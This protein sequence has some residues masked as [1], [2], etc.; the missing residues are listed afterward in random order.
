MSYKID[1]ETIGYFLY[2][3]EQEQA[4]DDTTDNR[5]PNDFNT[6]DGS[7]PRKS[8]NDNDPL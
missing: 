6:W 7:G 1:L 4:D 2:M 5:S 3:S 8:E